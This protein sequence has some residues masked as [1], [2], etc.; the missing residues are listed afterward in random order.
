MGINST[1][2]AGR[3]ER[4]ERRTAT[5]VAAR[6]NAPSVKDARVSKTP[7]AY[8][9]DART[10]ARAAKPEPVSARKGPRMSVNVVGIDVAKDGLDVHLLPSAT[11]QRLT[12]DAQ[13]HEQLVQL[14]KDQPVQR[15]VLEASGGYERVVA[16]LLVAAGLPVVVVNPRQVR[17]F[18]KATGKLAKT[19]RIDAAILAR[20]ADAIR[21]ELRPWP[22]ENEQELRETLARRSQLVGLRTMESNRLKQ[23][24]TKRVQDSLKAVL[25]TLDKQLDQLDDQLGR[26]IQASPAWQAKVDLYQ[27][28][29]GIG[30][31]TARCLVAELPELGSCT[32]Q[33]IAALVGVAPMN[34]DSGTY[35]GQ[36]MIVGGRA[37]VRCALYMATFSAVRHNPLIKT[38][39]QRFR[40]AGKPAKV[41]L[42][43]CMRK[44]LVILNAMAR[45]NQSWQEFHNQS[46]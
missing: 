45:K 34:R 44:F 14:L 15:I 37:S 33:Q 19:D 36:R 31:Q 27:S 28:T 25:K 24:R 29:P 12:N 8:M 20:F 40:A 35:R 22:S 39:Y 1:R 42:V 17:D 7:A 43:A 41:A 38:A 18:A 5:R 32:R 16:S 9:P 11:S 2:V 30:P 6:S 21:P 13:G 26:L 46:T 10:V 23:A 3:S 4:S